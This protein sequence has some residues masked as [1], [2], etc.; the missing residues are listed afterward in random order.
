MRNHKKVKAIRSKFGVVGYAVWSMTL[1]YLTGN[2]GNVFEYSDLEFELMSGDFG[3][4]A[5]E[6]RSVIDYCIS[7]EMLFN[8]KGFVKSESLDERLA[9]VYAKRGVAKELSQK[10]RREHGKFVIN[11]TEDCGV[12]VTEMPHSKVK[13]SKVNESI[14]PAFG[15][16]FFESKQQAS[17]EITGDQ[18][19]I[20]RCQIL[21]SNRGWSS[22]NDVDIGALLFHFLE[23][24]DDVTKKPRDDVRQHFKN[25]LNSKELNEL[26]KTAFTIRSRRQR[27]SA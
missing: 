14:T 7:L 19:E 13:Y 26:T 8:V 1:E 24:N 15:S 2:D 3:V 16:D 23:I 22:V 6:I 27:Q 21:L 18:I 9:P 17:K 25:W 4:S 5:T 11:N 20:E 12:S 10:Q